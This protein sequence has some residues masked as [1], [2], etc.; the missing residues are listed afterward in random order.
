MQFSLH[1]GYFVFFNCEVDNAGRHSSGHF[2][3]LTSDA[4]EGANMASAPHRR[5]RKAARVEQMQY[6]SDF[7]AVLLD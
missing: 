5:R 1:G 3:F 4:A 2:S 6:L 7:L